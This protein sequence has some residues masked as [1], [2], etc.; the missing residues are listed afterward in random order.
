VTGNIKTRR[1][2][3]TDE[4]RRPQ[5]LQ[6]RVGITPHD[7]IIVIAS[8]HEPE[9]QW[10]LSALDPVFAAFPELKVI[11]IPRHPERFAHVADLLH[12]HHPSSTLKEARPPTKRKDVS[13]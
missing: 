3:Q 12:K 5:P 6:T 2:R 9:E 1:S 7:R 13:S 10:L 4:Q 11:L 8:T